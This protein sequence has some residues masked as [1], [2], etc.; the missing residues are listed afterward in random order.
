MHLFCQCGA[1]AILLDLASG[2]RLQGS[3][4]RQLLELSKV[5]QPVLHAHVE[6]VGGH[7]NDRQF[8]RLL[9]SQP[10]LF[11]KAACHIVA[12]DLQVGLVILLI[13]YI[14]HLIETAKNENGAG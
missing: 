12:L 4:M 11:A 5:G 8:G 1:A 10:D 9:L 13:L 3:N 2:G 6:G 7:C 14:S